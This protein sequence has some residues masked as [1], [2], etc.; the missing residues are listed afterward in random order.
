MG[1]RT[2]ITLAAA[3]VVVGGGVAGIIALTNGGN[4]GD[5][6]GGGGTGAAR[7][8]ADIASQLPSG[9]SDTVDTSGGTVN[10]RLV[11]QG[12]MADTIRS[13]RANKI[14][15]PDDPE[16]MKLLPRNTTG[17]EYVFHYSDSKD[18]GTL[19]RV[20]AGRGHH[21]PHP[22]LQFMSREFISAQLKGTYTP[23][24]PVVIP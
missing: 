8:Q 24:A 12:D 3:I 15:N 9:W 6:G 18:E 7:L 16:M 2:G 22:E 10:V 13:L 20:A 14:I 19:L 17:A 21:S 1:R 4:S 5:G 23:P 11:H